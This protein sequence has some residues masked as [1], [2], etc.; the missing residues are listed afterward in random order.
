MALAMTTSRLLARGH[1]VSR[2][3]ALQRGPSLCPVPHAPAPTV[4]TVP[5]R[6][7]AGPLAAPIRPRPG[8]ASPS[9]TPS[10]ASNR[11]DRIVAHAFP[12]VVPDGPSLADM[13]VAASYW[14]GR[15]IILFT[16]FFC[17]LNWM[18]YRALRLRDEEATRAEE[19]V[20]D[21]KPTKKRSPTDRDA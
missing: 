6:D 14:A 13:L 17:T 21:Q 18:H 19:E 11:I 7:G 15:A 1:P 20:A 12:G 2:R 4:P 9:R 10:P 8:P 3:W 5:E 16:M